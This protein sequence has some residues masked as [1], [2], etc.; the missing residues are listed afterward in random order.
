MGANLQM[1][2]AKERE[3]VASNGRY[4]T[5]RPYS[6]T[7]NAHMSTAT[8]YGCFFTISGAWKEVEF[9]E[10]MGQKRQRTITHRIL[11]S[12]AKIGDFLATGDERRET[13]V[14]DCHGA[15]V[16]GI[17]EKKVLGLDVTVDYP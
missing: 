3:S 13:K 12:S 7:P 2:N 4:L 10:E 14:H 11:Q 16:S 9:R 15:I 1:T 17:L 5:V 8:S 6:T